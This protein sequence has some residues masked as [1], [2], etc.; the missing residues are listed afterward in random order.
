LN[1]LADHG[2]VW[3]RAVSIIASG[4]Q[5][6]HRF[7][8]LGPTPSK[9]RQIGLGPADLVM[10]AAKIAR[11]MRDHPAVG[12][13]LWQRLPSQI[14][15]AVAGFPSNR[16]DG[17]IVVVILE[18]DANDDPVVVPI[19]WDAGQKLNIVLSVYGRSASTGI[20]GDQWVATQLGRARAAGQK[21]FGN[22]S[23]ADAKPKPEPAE[24]TSWSSGSIPVDRSAEPKRN[25]LSLRKDSTK[26]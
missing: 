2:G 4:L 23:S 15:A 7:V 17:S 14:A 11:A 25:I 20:E 21:C 18:R 24:A 3:Q 16:E 19:L 5:Y 12:P 13:A 10:S 1:D 22:T 6:P 26:S 9:L 8:R